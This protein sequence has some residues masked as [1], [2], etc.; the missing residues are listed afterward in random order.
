VNSI[1][2][3]QGLRSSLLLRRW[4][5]GTS[6]ITDE[7]V[8]FVASLYRQRLPPPDVARIMEDILD[9]DEIGNKG[10]GAVELWSRILSLFSRLR[11]ILRVSK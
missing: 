4:Y 8:V 5:R 10:E 7:E 2:F 3:H 6:D 11:M 9:E 1:K